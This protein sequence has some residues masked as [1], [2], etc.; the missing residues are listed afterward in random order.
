MDDS[1][2][3]VSY[4]AV[5]L[6]VN[7]SVFAVDYIAGLHPSRIGWAEVVYLKLVNGYV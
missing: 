5:E 7:L 2:L 6:G 1:A 3:I 4:L